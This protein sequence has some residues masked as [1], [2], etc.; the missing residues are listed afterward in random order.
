ML[1]ETTVKSRYFDRRAVDLKA[2]DIVVVACMRNEVSRLPHFLKYY[3]GLGVNHFLLID[4]NSTDG[5]EQFLGEQSDVTYFHT[6][7]SYRGSS[8]GRLW[9]QEV[10]DDYAVGHWVLTVDVDELLTF[11]AAE[12]LDLRDLCNYMDKNGHEGLFS[13][14]LDMYSDLP[15]S[16]T[17]H[18]E[19]SDFLETCPFFETDTYRLA[20]GA[21]PPFLGVFGGPR[22][23]MFEESGGTG[24]GPMMKKIPLVKWRPGFS[25]I[26]STHSHRFIQLSDVTGAL[27]HFKFFDTFEKVAAGDSQ[28]GDR[29]QQAHYSTYTAHVESD[30]SFYGPQSHRLR[31]PRDL[32]QLGVMCVSAPFESFYSYTLKERGSHSGRADLLPRPAAPEGKLTLRSVAA[33][34]PFLQNPGLA[35]YFGLAD[36]TPRKDRRALVQEMRKHVKVVEVR[37]D[38]VLL[39]IDEAALH[40]WH[41]NDLGIA[42]FVD[43]LLISTVML[44]GSD[45]ALAVDAESLEPS[46]CRVSVDIASAVR[47]AGQGGD[48]ASVEVLLFDASD[49]HRGVGWASTVDAAVLRALGTRIFSSSWHMNG[50][51]ASWDVGFNGVADKLDSGM[52]RGW[53][54]DVERRTFE[55]PITIYANGRLVAFTVPSRRRADLDR[56]AEVHPSARGKG[57]QQQIPFG[58]FADSGASDVRIEAFIAGTNIRLRR[59]PL[60]QPLHL[61]SAAWDAR[62]RTWLLAP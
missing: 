34:W 6:T 26:Y 49:E 4:N 30:L 19:G 52:L 12:V 60:I 17:V 36:L 51:T 41:S 28:R 24:N 59:T 43:G 56:M 23:R 46:I 39:R 29:R 5:T 57:F 45:Q 61:S 16:M 31:S 8:A 10:A 33:L 42:I 58:Y 27:L 21:N 32:V 38:H 47:A 53:V 44:D 20:P 50:A 13:I 25:Y 22:G 3:R 55:V 1:N 54:Y 62:A 9:M 40:R 15:L 37:P 48:I 11:P 18:E 35:R 14:M 7:A 2:D